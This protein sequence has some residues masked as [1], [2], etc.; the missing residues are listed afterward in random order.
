MEIAYNT[1][2][3]HLYEIDN[4][5][6]H[7]ND[8]EEEHED[9]EDDEEDD[10]E[11][12]EDDEE[13]EDEEDDEDDEI[14]NTDINSYSIN[15]LLELLELNNN[16]NK[17]EIINKIHFV[18][19][20]FKNT[21][22]LDFFKEVETK[23]ISAYKNVNNDKLPIGTSFINNDN[24]DNN[25]NNNI[26]TN[27]CLL[28]PFTILNKLDILNDINNVG[29]RTNIDNETGDDDRLG[30]NRIDT[31]EDTTMKKI[32]YTHIFNDIGLATINQD[33]TIIRYNTENTIHNITELQLSSI[34]F[35]KP[36][37]FSL[38]NGNTRFYITDSSGG[39][40]NNFLVELPDSINYLVNNND[41]NNMVSI[42]NSYFQSFN[43]NS[44]IDVFLS[45]IE[46]YLIQGTGSVKVGFRLNTNTI[47]ND[48]SII[49]NH[50]DFVICNNGNM[51]SIGIILGFT[52]ELYNGTSTDTIIGD[53]KVKYDI[54]DLYISLNDY[55]FNFTQQY[56]MM[57]KSLIDKN[58]IAFVNNS[59]IGNNANNANNAN[60]GDYLRE[61]HKNFNTITIDKPI[62][63]YNGYIN[64]LYFEIKIFDKKGKLQQ[65][66]IDDDFHINLSI[67]RE[68]RS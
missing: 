59:D 55:T 50:E 27:D 30:Y 66:P 51:N 37:T 1:D 24:N 13:D 45:Y 15:D 42:M 43:N 16:P 26:N 58:I 9:E 17:R 5:E 21:K 8:D 20:R 53:K 18:S 2:N 12:E 23:I 38:Y 68:I 35:P 31:N 46:M 57:N 52:N 64:L 14:F 56:V 40:G 3:Y 65:I 49:F 47:S 62:R 54:G 41:L 29:F 36:Y 25:D 44:G 34:A 7:D 48:F 60:N 22:I 10:E 19:S 28:Q 61:Y 4:E 11:K 32:T 6:E 33:K 63:V 67:T 39:L